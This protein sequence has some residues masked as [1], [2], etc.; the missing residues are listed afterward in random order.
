M[1]TLV[2]KLRAFRERRIA[3]QALH[4]RLDKYLDKRITVVAGSEQLQLRLSPEGAE[5]PFQSSY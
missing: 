1:T 3:L 5:V 2:T 4:F